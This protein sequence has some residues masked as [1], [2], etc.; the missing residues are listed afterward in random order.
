VFELKIQTI[1]GKRGLIVVP[2]AIRQLMQIEE[3]EQVEVSIIS[4]DEI[5]I[6]IIRE[7]K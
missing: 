5:K 4:G 6:K 2:S 7:E 3:G 1:I